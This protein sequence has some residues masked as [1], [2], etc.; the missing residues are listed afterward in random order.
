MDERARQRAIDAWGYGLDDLIEALR[1]FRESIGWV[2]DDVTFMRLYGAI[3]AAGGD[4][5]G[6]MAG[7]VGIDDLRELLTGER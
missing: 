6:F 7:D 2:R 4:L 1:N 3:C 5:D